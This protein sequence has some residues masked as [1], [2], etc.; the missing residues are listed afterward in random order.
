M[1]QRLRDSTELGA[2][3]AGLRMTAEE[4][5][6]LPDDGRWYELVDGIVFMSPSPTPRHQQV[7]LEI[8]RQLANYLDLHP[9]GIVLAETDVQLGKGPTGGDLVY[10]PEVVVVAQDQLLDP[11]GP[12]RGAP[13]LAVE[14][15]SP[16]TRAY[17]T[18]TKR[19]DYERCGV[20][21]YWIV[22]PELGTLT[23]LVLRDGRFVE[24]HAVGDRFAS[25]AVRGFVLE[26]SSIRAK[27][28]A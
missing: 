19:L 28:K 7:M 17:D 13:L 27:F 20:Q 16:G 5:F 22:D 9:V 21:E 2:G 12:L 15:V 8:A 24:A 26:L 1:I 6:G 18:R 4:F 23:F 3:F 25:T 10:R 14:V 11:D